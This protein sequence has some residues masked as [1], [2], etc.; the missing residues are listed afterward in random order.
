MKPPKSSPADSTTPAADLFSRR[1]FL[2][3]SLGAAAGL[4][5]LPERAAA[6][7]SS[8]TIDISFLQ[9]GDP[10]YRAFEATSHGHNAIV[11][12]NIKKMMALTADSPMPGPD[13]LGK[14]LGVIN[15][16]DIVHSGAEEDP[17]TK[18]S[19]TKKQALEKQWANYVK[20][21]G[22]LGN[23]PDTLIK[24][25]VYESYG[26]HDQDGFLKEVSDR[27][28]ERGTKLPNITAKSGNFTY[29]KSFGKISVSGVHYA[30][31]WGPFHFVN[32]NI[33]V[34]NGDERYPCSGSYTFLK[35]YLEKSV[36]QSGEPVFII[37]HLPPSTGAEGDW[38]LADRKAF[39]EL[40]SKYNIVGILIGHVHSYGFFPWNGPDNGS[41]S[42]PVFQCDALHHRG[43]SQGIFTAFRILGSTS[44]NK[45]TIYHAQYLRNETWGKAVA[46]EI[47][48]IKKA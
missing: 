37:V 35:D 26:N 20:D 12:D 13:K 31:K 8:S 2:G 30:W 29:Q 36:A 28:A 19:L 43:A 18:E 15:A 41:F 16:G 45:A 25:P 39:Y 40:A 10:H 6:A 21:F 32:A 9:I 4:A 27:I 5:M 24:Y 1:R 34:G 33:R 3:T 48:L 23:E 44:D 22:S 47:S 38:P 42:I 14:P 17:E 46:T 7:A 11:R